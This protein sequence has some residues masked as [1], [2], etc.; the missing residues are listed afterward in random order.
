MNSETSSDTF[1]INI[2]TVKSCLFIRMS[3]YLLKQLEQRPLLYW[4]VEESLECAKIG[5]YGIGIVA[6]AQLLKLFNEKT[7][8]SRHSVAHKFLESRPTREMFD[9]VVADFKTAAAERCD[10]ESRKFRTSGEFEQKISAEWELF[11]KKLHDLAE[12]PKRSA[13]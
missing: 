5:Y 9:A 8:D 6:F 2:G 1:Y 4:S 12:A 10:L 11:I 3:S 13:G 7:P